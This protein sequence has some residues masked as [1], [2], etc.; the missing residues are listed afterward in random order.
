[1]IGEERQNERRGGETRKL[2]N[3]TGQHRRDV[4]NE[5]ARASQ[6]MG[7]ER[8]HGENGADE[9]KYSSQRDRA[10]GG[11]KKR[12]REQNRKPF[13]CA[14]V[15]LSAD[16]QHY[17]CFP[18]LHSSELADQDSG[19]RSCFQICISNFGNGTVMLM[20]CEWNVFIIPICKP[21][22][23]F[24]QMLSLYCLAWRNNVLFDGNQEK[25][26]LF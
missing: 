13:Q 8:G 14:D 1:M 15:S 22:M 6:E 16:P 25:T 11:Q 24:R 7:E 10:Q 20:M 4:L 19:F 9:M 3:E 18:F 23:C 5:T 21:M 26:F 2:K 12:W 17:P